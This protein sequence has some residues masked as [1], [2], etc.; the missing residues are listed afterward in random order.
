MLPLSTTKVGA[1]PRSATASTA[2]RQARHSSS[3]SVG[4]VLKMRYCWLV[5]R[6][7]TMT[8]RRVTSLIRTATTGTSSAS[9][10]SSINPPASP[11]TT[12]TAVAGTSKRRSTRATFTP[13]PPGSITTFW[14]RSFSSGCIS[15]TSAEVSTV[16]LRVTVTITA[17]SSVAGRDARDRRG[18][19]APSRAPVQLSAGFSR[20]R[21]TR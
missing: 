20:P 6:S 18:D 4:P 15:S 17:P 11:P 13:P 8:A 1:G 7:N 19:T 21:T 9:R 16:G 3:A 5:A 14:A 12:T 10:C 2:W